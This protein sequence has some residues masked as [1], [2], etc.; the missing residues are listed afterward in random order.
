LCTVCGTEPFMIAA[1][2]AADTAN[3][4]FGDPGAGATYTFAFECLGNGNVP[5]LTGTTSVVR[6]GIMNRY[7]AGGALDESQQMFR[8]FA[9]GM[10]SSTAANPTGSIVPLA[11]FGVNDSLDGIWASTSP[12]MCATG[13]PI[14]VSRALCGLYSRFDNAAP[15]DICAA[16]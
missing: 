15:P 9:G 12:N 5:P 6:Y 3:F 14:G 8:D 7:D 2:D 16:N 13:V 10:I 11:C 4:G 1:A